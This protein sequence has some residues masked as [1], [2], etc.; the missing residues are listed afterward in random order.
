MF[1]APK[2]MAVFVASITLPIRTMPQLFV[3][4]M[5]ARQCSNGFVPNWCGRYRPGAD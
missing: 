1:G 3:F 4:A 2:S 5:D